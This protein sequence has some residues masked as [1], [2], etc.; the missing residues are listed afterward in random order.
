M[1][2]N[3]RII[4]KDIKLTKCN[5]KINNKKKPEAE[6]KEFEPCFNYGWFHL[7][8]YQMFK[9]GFDGFKPRLKFFKFGLRIVLAFRFK[10]KLA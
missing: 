4:S 5:S 1:G 10:N 7:K 6:F 9:L 8:L 2:Q 3:M